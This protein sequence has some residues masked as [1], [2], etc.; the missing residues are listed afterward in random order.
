MA[1]YRACFLDTDGHIISARTLRCAD[2]E[3]ARQ[4]AEKLRDGRVIEVWDGR[5]LV[6]RVEAAGAD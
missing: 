2:D 3:S 4:E 5:R 1:P 6:H